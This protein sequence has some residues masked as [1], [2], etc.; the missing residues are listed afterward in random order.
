M[1]DY[2]SH[3]TMLNPERPSPLLGMSKAQVLGAVDQ[4]VAEERYETD[5]RAVKPVTEETVAFP[6][7]LAQVD[8][9]EQM[10]WMMWWTEDDSD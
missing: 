6:G 3:S 10:H 9:M 4:V 5:C 7:D 1:I 8:E 2:C